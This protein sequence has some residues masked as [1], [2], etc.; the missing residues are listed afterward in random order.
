[1]IIQNNII[2][3][4]QDANALNR[5]YELNNNGEIDHGVIINH[6]NEKEN[7][8]NNN[9]TNKKEKEIK[10]NV[11][12]KIINKTNDN[13]NENINS[14]L[15]NKNEKNNLNVEK[16]N[17]IKINK[18]KIP[19]D[20]HRNKNSNIMN[21]NLTFSSTMVLDDKYIKYMENFGYKKEY[22]QKCILNNELNYCHATYYL[23]LNS[24]DLSS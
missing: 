2:L 11:N 22:I 14:D 17:F 10:E 5:Q 23:L 20:T 4:D 15:Y 21:S 18:A 12:A 3:Y 9:N 7:I 6:S 13:D 24:Q 16:D 1:M 19:Y 8:I